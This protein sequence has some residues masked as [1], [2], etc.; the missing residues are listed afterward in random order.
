MKADACFS[1]SLLFLPIY[2]KRSEFSQADGFVSDKSKPLKETLCSGSFYG[3]PFFCYF[4]LIIKSDKDLEV[5]SYVLN[6]N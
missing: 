3:V 4:P 1:T 2:L 5:F 6:R